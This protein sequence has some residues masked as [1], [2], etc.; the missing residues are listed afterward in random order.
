MAT[1]SLSH[2]ED[3]STAFLIFTGVPPVYSAIVSG[4]ALIRSSS[5]I[6]CISLSIASFR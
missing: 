4:A 2:W 6:C 1:T 3:I 5:V